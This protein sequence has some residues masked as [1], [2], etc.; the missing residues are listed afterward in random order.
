MA[1]LSASGHRVVLVV[2]T[3]GEEGEFDD[4]FLDEGE[5]LEQRRVAETEA[6][7]VLLGVDR[8]EYLGYRDSGMMGEPT[9][10]SPSS[11]W[12]ADVEEAAGRLAAIAQDE[13]A[14]ALTVY[15]DHG[16]YDHPDHIQVHRVGHRAG[17]I[18]R[19]PRVLEATMNRDRIIEMRGS[20]RGEDGK[21]EGPTD[22][23]YETLG[24]PDEQITT[25]VD[26]TSVLDQKRAAMAAHAS[27][28]GPDSWFFRLPP[29]AF[30]AAFGT[31]WYVRT[32]PA[33]DGSIPN[34]RDHGLL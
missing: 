34:D 3:R 32:S 10:E 24:T 1:L 20:L 8:I 19:I 6:A 31:E 5:S 15:D 17:E 30:E 14:D 23:V 26:V 7:G 11:F 28:I 16:G 4:G 13:G 18:A 21:D 33:F 27:Q 25:A 2:A 12:Q 29:K 9:N 22:A